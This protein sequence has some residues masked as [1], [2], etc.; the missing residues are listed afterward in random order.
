MG[1]KKKQ[2]DLDGAQGIVVGAGSGGNRRP[3]NSPRG[4]IS[5]GELESNDAA[6]S[7]KPGFNRATWPS[8]SNENVVRKP[9][10]KR[11]TDIRPL[12]HVNKQQRP[13]KGERT[14]EQQEEILDRFRKLYDDFAD[15]RRE[16]FQALQQRLGERKKDSHS[17]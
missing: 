12:I 10:A 17:H 16:L 7:S 13:K 4:G 14:P 11:A 1:R 15:F 8:A 5:W 9:K 6:S 3:A 2:D